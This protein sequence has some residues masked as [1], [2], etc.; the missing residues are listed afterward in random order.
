MCLEDSVFVM[1]RDDELRVRGQTIARCQQLGLQVPFARVE[2]D[3]ND[4][5]EAHT[6]AVIDTTANGLSTFSSWLR[7]SDF[8]SNRLESARLENRIDSTRI[9]SS[10]LWARAQRCLR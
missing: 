10:R 5:A 4:R 8:S 2:H 7:F 9:G 1:T 3:C 6:I